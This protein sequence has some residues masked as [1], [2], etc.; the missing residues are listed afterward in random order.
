MT[1]WSD[2]CN[3]IRISDQLVGFTIFH[4]FLRA[5]IFEQTTL[6]AGSNRKS[7]RNSE[8]NSQ[9]LGVILQ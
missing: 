4:S 1:D 9:L 5:V 3:L 8:R 6:R 2:R 7:A